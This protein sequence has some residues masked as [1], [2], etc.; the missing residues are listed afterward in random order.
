MRQTKETQKGITL[1]SIVVTIIV[2]L[3]LAGI[4]I[5]TL[6]GDSGIIKKSKEAKEQTEISE[7]KEVV[8]RAIVQAMGNNKKGDLIESKLQEQLDKIASSGKVEVSDNG[9]KFEVVFMKSNRYYN[10][11]K[12]GNIVEEG[13]IVID[14]SPGDITKDENGD[15]IQEGQPYEIWCIED[16]VAFSNMVN[17]NGIKLENG[18]AIEINTST[19]FTNKTV[20]L[21]RNLNFKSKYSYTNSKRTD[22]GDINGNENDGNTLINEMTTGT[23]FNPIGYAQTVPSEHIKLGPSFRGIFDG[24]G[25]NI[26]NIYINRSDISGLFGYVSGAK[27]IKNVNISGEIIAT[28][29]FAGGIIGYYNIGNTYVTT[30]I[31]KC[32]N[33][34]SITSN[35]GTT[36]FWSYNGVSGGIVGWVN[37]KLLIDSCSNFGNISGEMSAG[38][39][40]G[41][42]ADYI[43]N[44]FNAGTIISSGS[45][46]TDSYAGGIVGGEYASVI[47]IE[48][49]YN[50]GDI[51]AKKVAGGIIGGGTAGSVNIKNSYNN[52]NIKNAT[53]KKA[54]VGN[55]AFTITNGYY[56]SSLMD[57][58]ITIDNGLIDIADKSSEEFINLL[59]SYRNDGE[60][61]YPIDW[62]RWKL[63]EKGYPVLDI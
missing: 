62:K 49:C 28:D 57:S 18:K 63:G 44:C 19:N 33:K 20:E 16:L 8:N 60:K 58:T 2:L 25:N 48:N 11:D 37:G 55:I 46:S 14:K 50:I 4:S 3:I 47:S 6:N 52:G 31:I 34:A 10:V 27:E 24:N 35:G 39:I 29:S 13:K 43:K 36:I 56:N 45:T 15:D 1:I 59:N 30:N 22:F 51:S 42:D 40:T 26:D 21:K 7:E 23:G 61:T 9:D 32:T 54:M 5:A 38:G 17:G 12:D 41:G 53:T